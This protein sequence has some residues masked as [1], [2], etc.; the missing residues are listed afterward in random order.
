MIPGVRETQDA[1]HTTTRGSDLGADV[2]ISH[3]ARIGPTETVVPLEQ[4][5]GRCIGRGDERH[6]VRVVL[7]LEQDFQRLGGRQDISQEFFD[8]D[9]FDLGEILGALSAGLGQVVED[10]ILHSLA[11][12][13]VRKQY[14]IDGH[15]LETGETPPQGRGQTQTFHFRLGLFDHGRGHE[16]GRTLVVC[17]SNHCLE[18]LDCVFQ[19]GAGGQVD[20]EGADGGVPQTCHSRHDGAGY[21]PG[22]DIAF[23]VGLQLGEFLLLLEECGQAGLVFGAAIDRILGDQLEHGFGVLNREFLHAAEEDV[24]QLTLFTQGRRNVV[25]LHDSASRQVDEEVFPGL[26]LVATSVVHD[27]FEGLVLTDLGFT[28]QEQV[29]DALGAHMRR[30]L[31]GHGLVAGFVV[32]LDVPDGHDLAVNDCNGRT[33]LADEGTAA[34][35]IM[36]GAFAE[37]RVV[38]GAERSQICFPHHVLVGIRLVQLRGVRAEERMLRHLGEA[39]RYCGLEFMKIHAYPLCRCTGRTTVIAYWYLQPVVTA[40]ADFPRLKYNIH[41]GISAT[42]ALPSYQRTEKWVELLLGHGCSFD[43]WP[44]KT[45]TCLYPQLSQIRIRGIRSTFG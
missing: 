42:I 39:L 36:L 37:M 22:V 6:Q 32:H 25:L 11:G 14:V 23:F 41:H 12:A 9:F 43:I 44:M 5:A 3:V 28:V 20:Q 1:V 40:R 38:L 34:R 21:R 4:A 24:L 7:V 18:F 45:P 31:V 16:C 27:F 17:R 2:G 19:L 29:R 33:D 13:A 26:R 8:I 15:V 10:R 35:A 30:H